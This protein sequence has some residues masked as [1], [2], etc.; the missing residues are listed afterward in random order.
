MNAS[1]ADKAEAL[2]RRIAD[3]EHRRYVLEFPDM[4]RAALNTMRTELQ[5]LEAIIGNL[6]PGS[7][8][9]RVAR[10]REALLRAQALPEAWPELSIV[11]SVA[12]L[13]QFATVPGEAEAAYV[14]C[15]TVVGADVLAEYEDG[16]LVRATTRGDGAQG[17]DVLAN[18]RAIGSV[19]LRL[20]R[21][22][23][24]TDSRATK[25]VHELKGPSTSSPAPP[26]PPRLQV[27]LRVGMRRVAATGLDR[28]RVDAGDPPYVDP[29]AAVLASLLCSD[30]A[31]THGRR[32]KAFTMGIIGAV[33]GVDS[34]WSLLS[35]LKGWGFAVSPISWQCKGIKELMDFVAL[36]Q[37]S[38]SRF[39]Y[40]LDGG[41]VRQDRRSAA[42]GVRLVFPKSGHRA[43]VTRVYRAV[44]RGGAVLP[45][46][47]LDAAKPGDNIPA[48]APVPAVDAQSVL[49][50]V[51]GSEVRVRSGP[52]APTISVMGSL[53]PSPRPLDCPSCHSPLSADLDAPFLTCTNI[54]CVARARAR[55]LH[56]FGPRGFSV[57]G[58][59]G[60][61]VDALIAAEGPLD[62]IAL[63]AL[64]QHD[65]E[66]ALP[67]RGGAVFSALDQGRSMPLWRLIF[68]LG[69][70]H[71]GEREARLI[72][73]QLF[74]LERFC[75]LDEAALD[76]FSLPGEAAQGL[77][78]WLQEEGSYVLPRLSMLGL[79]ILPEGQVYSAPLAGRR[80]ALVGSF[81]GRQPALSEALERNGA[82]LQSQL[83][84][85]SELAVI[86]AGGD[87]LVAQAEAYQVP[88]V[89]VD[90]IDAL[91]A[92]G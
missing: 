36:L 67:G 62:L 20:R 50:L 70:R 71:V 91:L 90:A 74:N 23:T 45:V 57:P 40:P 24:R 61:L 21:P 59:D 22:G 48:R 72:A 13:E 52:V 42:R 1:N 25:L 66:R 77:R 75:Q 2:R 12:E 78:A 15:A 28:A 27:A 76:A 44:G 68:L 81:E 14:A 69:I 64:S 85:L 49:D 34:E 56:L 30:P 19:P 7:P 84:R 65:F 29:K 58:A 31:V 79:E 39:E 53:P 10:P 46:A 43:I 8:S 47:V 41:L 88:T 6:P 18:L 33:E 11:Q 82:T 87:K 89:A 92:E 37:K 51:A 26:F 80:V 4:P 73:A 17:Q 55:L 54:N 63:Y 3:S 5:E 9:Q 60:S 35:A 32:L 16:V 83:S 38:A 86:G